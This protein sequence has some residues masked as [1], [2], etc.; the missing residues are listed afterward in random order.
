MRV[1]V[2]GLGKSGTTALIYAIRAAMPAD[3][4][5][6]FEPRAYIALSATNV[7]AK[8]LLH[9]KFP[10][11]PAFY[12]QFERIILLLRD[13][14]DL[15]ISKALYRIYG[16]TPLHADRAKLDEYVAL[17]RAKEED[18]RSV[19]FLRI[20]ALFQTLNGREP[21]TDAGIT[22]RLN[23]IA[24][25]QSAFPEC[26]VYKY[27]DLVEGRFEAVASFASLSADRMK[28]NVPATLR[29]VVRSRRAGNWRD[30]F[31][32]EDVEHYRPLF[33][34]FM[35]RHG[36]ADDWTLNAAPRIDP[37]EGSE[38]VMRLA[39]ERRGEPPEDAG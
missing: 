14:R 26:L 4:E 18:P 30:W 7:A 32:P 33:A 24:A 6:L 16:G 23:D 25:F 29:R 3:T 36:Y 20:V 39:R 8:V 10:M 11:D 17:L 31:T 1:V 2:V 21:K 9:P 38:Y 37:K 22:R 5:V 35:S 12:R 19:S 15:L 13:P 27:E 34:S 28:P